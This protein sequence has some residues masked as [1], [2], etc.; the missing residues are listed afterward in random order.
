MMPRCLA[1]ASMSARSS[2]SRGS[3]LNVSVIRRSQ[4]PVGLCSSGIRIRIPQ[5]RQQS[6]FARFHEF[7]VA[8]DLVIVTQ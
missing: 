7:G 5:L 6:H 4:R 8:I 2:R 3:L 1:F